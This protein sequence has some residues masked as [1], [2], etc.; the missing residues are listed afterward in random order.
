E[1]EMI[2]PRRDIKARTNFVASLDRRGHRPQRSAEGRRTER[3][4]GPLAQH[5]LDTDEVIRP[6]VFDIG[7][8]RRLAEGAVVLTTGSGLCRLSRY[9]RSMRRRRADQEPR[10]RMDRDTSG[11]LPARIVVAESRIR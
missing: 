2:G 5:G 3:R 4:Q 9:K 8:P 10:D 1:T 7:A 11:Q 6:R